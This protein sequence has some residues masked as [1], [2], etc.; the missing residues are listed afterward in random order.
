MNVKSSFL[1]YSHVK[2]GVFILIVLLKTQREK[3]NFKLILTR[4]KS[5]LTHFSAFKR[6]KTSLNRIKKLEII[7]S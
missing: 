3:K 1:L 2:I 4:F 7:L 5:A 6:I